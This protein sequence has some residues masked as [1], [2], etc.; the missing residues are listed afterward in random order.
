LVN[1]VE[2]ELVSELRHF[3]LPA[4]P[5]GNELHVA[6]AATIDL[7]DIAPP[8]IT[9]PSWCSIWRAVLGAV[10]FSLGPTGVF[11]TELLA[12]LQ[13]HYGAGFN[14]RNLPGSWSSTANFLRLQAF[15]VKDGVFSIDDFVPTGTR[16]DTAKIH[17][18][19]SALLRDVG[20]AAGR[21]RLTSEAAARPI[22]MPRGLL[23]C[24]GEEQ[25]KLKCWNRAAP[26]KVNPPPRGSV[27][28]STTPSLAVNTDRRTMNLQRW[29]RIAR[30]NAV[31]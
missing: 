1:D 8:R 19:A 11:K 29:D 30:V 7:I 18:E 21:G 20:N 24:T 26:G 22:K 15:T 25:I 2:V 28:R 27:P 6:V 17:R 31:R 5:S 13:A 14:S 4:P 9:A 12:L 23:V 3:A 16:I 10:D